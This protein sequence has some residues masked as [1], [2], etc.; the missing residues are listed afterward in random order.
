M[1]RYREGWQAG[2]RARPG[3]ICPLSARSDYAAGWRDGQQQ[4]E[5]DGP[6]WVTI[7]DA[8]ARVLSTPGDRPAVERYAITEQAHGWQW[9]YTGI[10]EADAREIAGRL[11]RN[12]ETWTVT[13]L[14]QPLAVLVDG[15]DGFT[16]AHDETGQLLTADT[17]RDLAERWNARCE[18]E[19]A[20]FQVF[21][22]TR[23]GGPMEP[24]PATTGGGQ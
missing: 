4:R 16:W 18:P 6:R 5:S 11:T 10:T 17:A 22:L 14:A 19:H 21:T 24:Q 2:Y 15:H 23:P 9:T 20:R 3:A 13:P 7:N 12:G 8:G 1:S